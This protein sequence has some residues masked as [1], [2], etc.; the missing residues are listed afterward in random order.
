M[1]KLFKNIIILLIVLVIWYSIY[2]IFF[3]STTTT[4]TKIINYTVKKWDIENSIK[5]TWVANLVDEQQI[6]FNQ[7]WEI[8]KVNF[9]A[10]DKVKKGDIIAELDMTDANNT[11]KQ[12]QINLSDSRINLQELLKWNDAKDKLQAKSTVINAKSKLVTL[13]IDIVTLES[14]KKVDIDKANNEIKI[15][16]KELEN[17][18]NTNQ[19]TLSDLKNQVTDKKTTIENTKIEYENRFY[20]LNNQIND[21]KT[22]IESYQ[23]DIDLAILELDNTKNE[24]NDTY[25]NSVVDNDKTLTNSYNDIRK[26]ISDWEKILLWIDN[27]FWISTTNMTKNDAFESYLSAKNTS[28]KVDTID[29]WYT[30]NVYLE[31][32]KSNFNVLKI[33]DKNQIKENLDLM[34]N[35]YDSISSLS[36]KASEAIIASVSSSTFSDSQI[37]SYYSEILWYLSTSN[38]N[39][40]LSK[41]DLTN[42]D[43]LINLD[44]TISKSN[45][46]TSQKQ[47]SIQDMENSILTMKNDLSSLEKS[48]ELTKTTYETKLKTL[49]NDIIISWK[50]VD[51]TISSNNTKY[52]T[53]QNDIVNKQKSLLLTIK[54]YDDKILTKKL[55]IESAYAD[56]QVAEENLKLVLSW[57]TVDKIALAKNSIA[58]Q[59]ISLENAKKTLDKYKI[60]APFN[61]IIWQIDFKVWDNI[62]TDESKY[63]YIKNPNLIEITST[64]DQLDVV[65]IKIWEKVRIIFDSFPYKE[66]EWSVSNISTSPKT[67]SWVTSY[68]IKITMDKKD[69]DI[70]SGMTAKLYIVINSKKGILLVPTQFIQTRWKSSFV[71]TP[72][73]KTLEIVTWISTSVDSEVISWLKEGDIIVRKV[74]ITSDSISNSLFVPSSRTWSSS[75][76]RWDFWGDWNWGTRNSNNR[77][78]DFWWAQ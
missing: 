60:K 76:T 51:L 29:K 37:N 19:N 64:V 14:Q 25:S 10:W 63:V 28:L 9:K 38:N 45:L 75:R 70:Y 8:K 33:D 49:A 66:F 71:E 21:K 39:I 2:V 26:A 16:Q 36:Q 1:K 74:T 42:I 56:I 7:A 57:T 20:D 4:T 3:K 50:S 15:L 12:S 67:T 48:L 5:V 13:K 77:S 6:R 54:S 78:W 65:K 32:L 11:I 24:S 22:S 23:K 34:Y 44:L 43:K 41:T 31:K 35:M 61:G 69:T 40:S 68:E 59:E 73:N 62:V 52:A 18:K 72:D 47:K 46:T 55:D 58:K 17:T 27:I 53:L 30:S